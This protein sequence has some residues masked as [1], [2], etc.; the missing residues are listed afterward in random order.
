MKFLKGHDG[1]YI[2]AET[3]EC[4]RVWKNNVEVDVGDNRE[5][6]LEKLRTIEEAEEKFIVVT[7][8]DSAIEYFE[9][10]SKRD[11]LTENMNLCISV[12]LILKKL[13]EMEGK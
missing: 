7:D 9:Q 13:K 5:Y 6:I 8:M 3:I 12:L 11:M 2:N 4:I 10:C 1:A